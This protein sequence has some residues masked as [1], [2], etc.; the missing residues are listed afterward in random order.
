MWKWSGW[1]GEGGHGAIGGEIRKKLGFFKRPGL[2]CLMEGG[3]W[4]GRWT[5]YFST[6][7][8][9]VSLHF[10]W[11]PKHRRLRY[12][13]GVS[14]ECL[15]IL[16]GAYHLGSSSC[17]FYREAQFKA[18]VS[19]MKVVKEIWKVFQ[20]VASVLG[21]NQQFCYEICNEKNYIFLG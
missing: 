4:G 9:L 5:F 7:N 18:S 10:G 20:G 21:N 12:L 8:I 19:S 11:H 17:H 3:A 16:P 6:I 14:M 15:H 13:F 2:P 1:R